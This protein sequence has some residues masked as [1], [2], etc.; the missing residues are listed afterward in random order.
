MGGV[1]GAIAIN[2]NASLPVNGN[3]PARRRRC[4]RWAVIWLRQ[5][6]G[7][8]HTHLTYTVRNLVKFSKKLYIRINLK[9]KEGE[10]F[11]LGSQ[12]EERSDSS[13]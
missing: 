8:E 3:E 7:A 9:F 6:N 13:H 12:F 5:L 2:L 1:L 10:L 4:R 11:S